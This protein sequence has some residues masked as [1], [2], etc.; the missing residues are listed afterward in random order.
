M[1]NETKV[2]LRQAD[3]LAFSASRSGHPCPRHIFYGIMKVP[4]KIPKRTQKIF[5]EGHR[6]EELT[7]KELKADG[8]RFK[9]SV[10]GSGQQEYA[11]DVQLKGKPKFLVTAHPDAIYNRGFSSGVLLP[12]CPIEIKGLHQRTWQGIKDYAT[13][14]PNYY[15]QIQIQMFVLDAPACLFVA[16]NKGW[17]K[18]RPDDGRH[19]RIV[20]LRD[21]ECLRKIFKALSRIAQ[22]VCVDRELPRPLWPPGD[23]AECDKCFYLQ[24]CLL[25]EEGDRKLEKREPK[26][27]LE[28]AEP[29]FVKKLHSLF[30]F[31][32]MLKRL[33]SL[34]DRLTSELKNF[35]KEHQV[36]ELLGGAVRYSLRDVSKQVPDMDEIRKRLGGEIPMKA[37]NYQA[38][39]KTKV[40]DLTEEEYQLIK[41]DIPK[42]RALLIGATDECE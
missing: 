33:E 22:G 2:L 41:G 27:L 40:R 3:T 8:I 14:P 35:M 25:D 6:Q 37:N 19:K 32:E 9:H 5:E 7:L 29:I 20:V 36:K 18:N 28:I 17:G 15:A 4:R 1:V 39:Y 30:L 16:R 24:R 13:I 34:E 26:P 21:E 42:P 11:R 38:L 12:G 31:K 10:L 23:D